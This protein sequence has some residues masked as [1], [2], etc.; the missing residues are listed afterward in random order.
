M[1]WR[2]L[3]LTLA[4]RFP[5]QFFLFSLEESVLVTSSQESPECPAEEILSSQTPAPLQLSSLPRRSYFTPLVL[6]KEGYF[7]SICPAPA[8][9]PREDSY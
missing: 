5:V 9:A 3:Q 4:C 7:N 1:T 8:N 2:S 6:I